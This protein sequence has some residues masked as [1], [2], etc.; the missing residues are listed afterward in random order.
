MPTK[1]K[2]ALISCGSSLWSIHEVFKNLNLIKPF[3]FLSIQRLLVILTHSI[4][5]YMSQRG[6]LYNLQEIDIEIDKLLDR[7]VQVDRIIADQ[8]KIKDVEKKAAILEKKVSDLSRVIHNLENEINTILRKIKRSESDLYGGKI[9][10][11]KELQAIQDEISSL[12][13]RKGQ[14][15]EELFEVMIAK[16]TIEADHA[17][18]AAIKKKIL[19][20][21]NEESSQLG[22]EKDQLSENLVKLSREKELI[23]SQISAD[24]REKYEKLRIKKNKL[25]VALVIEDACSAC[26]ASIVPA[27]I[28]KIKSPIDEYYC[29]I[30][31][32]ILYYG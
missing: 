21:K 7:S 19:H 28:Q 20:E 27:E 31:K 29:Q 16:E 9:Q 18:V 5:W 13:K 1:A 25:A 8:S 24:L 30:C 6:F 15:E 10:N 17:D 22:T 4:I 26:G 2:K 32:R 14:F 3:I 11:S 12:K 23:S